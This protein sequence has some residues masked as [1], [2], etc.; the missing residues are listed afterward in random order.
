VSRATLAL[1]MA[2]ALGAPV[3]ARAQSPSPAAADTSAA[4]DADAPYADDDTVSV[5]G[6]T[7]AP[8]KRALEALVPAV[9][10]APFRIEPGVRPF[11]HRLTFSPAFGRLG[12]EPLYSFRLAYQPDAWLGYEGSVEHNPGRAVHAALHMFNVVVRKPLPGRLQPYAS[13]G[14]GMVLVFPGRSLNADPVTKNAVAVGGGIE[15]YVRGDLA[16]RGEVRRATVFG[17]EGDRDRIVAF[18]YLQETIGLSFHRT[19]RP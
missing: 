5:T 13:A 2:L 3:A 6:A 10:A 16:L 11:R 19:L 18:D 4:W 12:S 9:A 8:R 15:F 1:L 7:A 14:Y 17:R